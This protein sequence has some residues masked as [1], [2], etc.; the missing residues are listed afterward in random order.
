[1]SPEFLLF[2]AFAILV[3]GLA[4][5]AEGK[6]RKDARQRNPERTWDDER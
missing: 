5:S 1:M 2:V 4:L 6:D 3:C